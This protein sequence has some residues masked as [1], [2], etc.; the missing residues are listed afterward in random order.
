MA[1]ANQELNDQYDTEFALIQLITDEKEKEAA[2]ADL[3]ARYNA[4]RKAAAL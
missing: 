1:A 4:D 2:M 3:N